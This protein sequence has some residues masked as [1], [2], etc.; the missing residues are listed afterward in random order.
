MISK[1]LKILLFIFVIFYY[2]YNSNLIEP[3]D[4]TYKWSGIDSS[5]TLATVC[6][7][8]GLSNTQCKLYSDDCLFH[9]PQF[10][11]DMIHNKFF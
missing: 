8:T 9:L 3:L 10:E 6:N 5:S 1:N 11:D 2:F 4:S 7:S